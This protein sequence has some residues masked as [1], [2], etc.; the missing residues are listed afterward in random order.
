LAWNGI[1]G[2]WRHRRAP[3]ASRDA[4]PVRAWQARFR[5]RQIPPL[6]GPPLFGNGHVEGIVRH[7]VSAEAVV[8]TE[9]AALGC[10]QRPDGSVQSQG[11]PL[12][13]QLVYRLVGY[14][15]L[16][17]PEAVAPAVAS[18]IGEHGTNLLHESAETLPG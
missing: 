7:P 8:A 18:E 16:E 13:A 3:R 4:A 2:R 14:Y 12:M 5:P 17:L 1:N 9:V 15:G 11:V 6:Q 10:Q